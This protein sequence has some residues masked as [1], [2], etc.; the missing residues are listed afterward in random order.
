MQV[1]RRSHYGGSDS[2][3][4]EGPRP[5]DHTGRLQR[6][7]RGITWRLSCVGFLRASGTQESG[8]FA[9]VVG[10]SEYDLKVT[11]VGH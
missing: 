11:Q 7:Q 2:E 3:N 9:R 8:M 4:E 6:S 1:R 10:R 5:G